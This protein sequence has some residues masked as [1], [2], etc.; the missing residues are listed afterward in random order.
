MS[1]YIDRFRYSWLSLILV[2]GGMKAMSQPPRNDIDLLLK[3][4]IEDSLLRHAHVALNVIDLRSER[5]VAQHHPDLAM[6]PASTLKLITC[7]MLFFSQ[8]E[9]ETF[10]TPVRLEGHFTGD[11]GFVG[12]L[13]VAGRGDPALGSTHLPGAVGIDSIAAQISGALRG[14][15]IKR[16]E[17]DLEVDEK[18]LSNIPENPEWLYYDLGNYYGGGCRA[19]NW[20]DNEVL[21]GLSAAEKPGAI[22]PLRWTR[23]PEAIEDFTSAVEGSGNAV[24]KPNV[25]VIGTSSNRHKRIYGNWKCCSDDSIVLRAAMYRPAEHFLRSLKQ[26]LV[27][28]GVSFSEASNGIGQQT[29]VRSLALTEIQSP[30]LGALARFALERSSN[31]YCEA[32]LHWM[33]NCFAGSADRDSALHWLTKTLMGAATENQAFKMLDGSG[34]SPKNLISASN[35]T[36]FLHLLTL[37]RPDKNFWEWIPEFLPVPE[38]SRSPGTKCSLRLKSGSMERVKAYA[39][40][41]MRG[42]Q[43]AYA[44]SIM[45]NNFV[46]EPAAVKRRISSFLV[47]LEELL[48]K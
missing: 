46:A 11:S 42:E 45:V 6:V 26:E 9:M 23:P 16:L 33:G 21:V 20:A 31:L 41:C 4:F 28:R 17:G 19:F 5:V 32:F 18:Y 36:A 10:A 7:G 24:I 47:D 8:A 14:L 40:Y 38:K 48:C 27:K 2:F 15:G 34:L 35:M 12:K 13:V 43:P 1:V 22:C 37:A 30:V 44:I 25:Y 39:G 3:S 29:N